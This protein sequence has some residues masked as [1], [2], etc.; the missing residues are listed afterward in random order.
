MI[1]C[2]SLSGFHGSFPK[3]HRK[4][5]ANLAGALVATEC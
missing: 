4:G 2:R 5:N 1:K 3:P